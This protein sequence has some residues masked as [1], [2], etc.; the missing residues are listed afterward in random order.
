MKSFLGLTQWFSEHIPALSWNTT[1]LRQMLT[2][3]S[4]T[5]TLH[6]T[7]SGLNQFQYIKKQM[8]Q[9]CTLAVYNPKAVVIL[10]TDACVEG[11]GCMLVQL[12]D[13]NHEVVVA[14]GSCSLSRAQQMYHIT[15]LE[16]LAF[17]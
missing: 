17:I 15:C 8:R 11:L 9:P 12:Q 5:S 13:D 2:Q 7:Q 1:A 10:Y 14:F 4:P 16:A 6:W 3:T